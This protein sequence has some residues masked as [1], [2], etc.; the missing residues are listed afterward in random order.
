M[1]NCL[2]AE[3]ASMY[4][5]S[6]ILISFVWF[7]LAWALSLIERKM[8]LISLIIERINQNAPIPRPKM[9]ATMKN[10]YPNT[11]YSTMTA[12][13][14]PVGVFQSKGNLLMNEGEKRVASLIWR[15]HR[16]IRYEIYHIGYGNSNESL[17]ESVRK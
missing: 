7:S 3:C 1:L 8:R 9:H 15:K 17:S 6:N 4:S 5:E 2:I 13:K 10:S 12:M 14:Y 11:M 16:V